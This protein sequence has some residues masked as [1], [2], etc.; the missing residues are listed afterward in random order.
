MQER[1]SSILRH[2][3]D[4]TQN[5]R[6]FMAFFTFRM[7]GQC[8]KR[9]YILNP[10][11]LKTSNWFGDQLHHL[12]KELLSCEMR[13]MLMNHRSG[14][15]RKGKRGRE[16]TLSAYFP[17][18]GRF[19]IWSLQNKVILTIIKK[20]EYITGFFPEIMVSQIVIYRYYFSSSQSQRAGAGKKREQ[21]EI[22]PVGEGINAAKL[23]K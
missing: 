18:V 8:Q 22:P 10:F 14:E 13:L 1:V 21:A 19:R 5:F 6:R 9:E 4:Q 12:V 16:R 2:F 7:R 3:F 20:Q 11:T 15:R 17:R 23:P